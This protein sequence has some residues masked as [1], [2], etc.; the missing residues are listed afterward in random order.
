MQ[1]P[2]EIRAQLAATEAEDINLERQSNAHVSCSLLLL[3]L[4]EL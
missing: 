2:E 3:Q 1:E 4:T